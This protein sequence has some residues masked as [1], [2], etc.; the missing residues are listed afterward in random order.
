[1]RLRPFSNSP[2]ELQQ[3]TIIEATFVVDIVVGFGGELCFLEGR[4]AVDQLL[5]QTTGFAFPVCSDERRKCDD[6]SPS[7]FEVERREVELESGK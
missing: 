3:S 4:Y 1:M 5:Y 7:S 6:S 2:S